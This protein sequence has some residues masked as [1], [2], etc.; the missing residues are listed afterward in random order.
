VIHDRAQAIRGALAAAAA[1]D[2]VLVAGKGHE[3]YQIIGGERRAFS[4]A[5]V[6]RAGAAEW[7]RA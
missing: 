2:V 1:E 7:G 6:V 3:A 4:D 5:A